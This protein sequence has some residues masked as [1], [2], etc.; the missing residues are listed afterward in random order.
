[1][2]FYDT[3]DQMNLIDT[4]RTFNPIEAEHILFKCIWNILQDNK[5]RL[6][7]FKKIEIISTIVSNHKD[8]RVEVNYKKKKTAKKPTRG[9]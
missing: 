4:Y 9:G 5:T 2:V 6:G 7:K 3:L 8:M 1:M